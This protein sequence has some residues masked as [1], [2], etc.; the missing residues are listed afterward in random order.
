MTDKIP[1]VLDAVFEC[2]LSMINQ[3]LTE[4]PEYVPVSYCSLA[5]GFSI[6]DPLF[7]RHRVAFFKLL[8]VI[9]INCFDSLLTIPA[10]QFKL[11]MDSVVW[12]T[13]HTMRDI[14]DLGLT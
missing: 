7:H 14:G 2:T 10:P 13:K 6:D 12:A 5:K 9:N 3:D 1:A 11:V 8:R 4:F